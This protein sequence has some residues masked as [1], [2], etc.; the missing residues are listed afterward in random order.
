[1]PTSYIES[2]LMTNTCKVLHMQIIKPIENKKDEQNRKESNGKSS[3][4]WEEKKLQRNQYESSHQRRVCLVVLLFWFM[5]IH[6]T[7]YV[8]M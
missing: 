8:C 6:C 2:G 4:F 7:M 5:N 3:N 1:M